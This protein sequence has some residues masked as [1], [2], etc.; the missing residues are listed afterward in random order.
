MLQHSMSH[1]RTTHM[2]IEADTTLDT[3]LNVILQL[4]QPS[5]LQPAITLKLLP[6]GKMPKAAARL[7]YKDFPY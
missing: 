2:L 6:S 5:E 3:W 4:L 1:D 7:S